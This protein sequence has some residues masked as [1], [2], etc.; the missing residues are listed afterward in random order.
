MEAWVILMSKGKYYLE[1]KWRDVVIGGEFT[2]AEGNDL[3]VP[4]PKAAKKFVSNAQA[5]E[6]MWDNDI[7]GIAI[8]LIFAI[9]R[10]K[11]EN[12]DNVEEFNPSLSCNFIMTR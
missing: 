8:P 5:E 12:Q 7:E 6:W 4:D 2:G 3:W 9:G 10:Y 1:T 11:Q